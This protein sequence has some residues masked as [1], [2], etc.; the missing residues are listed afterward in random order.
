[1][2]LIS[3][4]GNINGRNPERE[5]SLDYVLEALEN[6]EVEI[7]VWFIDDKWYLGH[8]KPQYEIHK[9]DIRIRKHRLWCHAKNIDAL[10][11]LGNMN[12]GFTNHRYFWHQGDDVT[13]TSTGHLWTFPGK[14]LTLKSICVLPENANYSDEDLKN[15]YGICSDFIE[16]YENY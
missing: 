14:Q 2:K 13:L 11:R 12:E 15:C 3:H 4:R 1:M 8:D 5:N 7:D 6:Y 16:K 10:Y 9:N